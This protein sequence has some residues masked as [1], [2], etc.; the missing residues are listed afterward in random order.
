MIWFNNKNIRNANIIYLIFC[1]IPWLLAIYMAT[2]EMS[3]G[4]GFILFFIYI[5]SLFPGVFF[6][7]PFFSNM[8]GCGYCLFIIIILSQFL[9]IFILNL[10][11]ILLTKILKK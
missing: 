5:F 8:T 4:F 7:Y 3:E 10:I 11:T 6:I 1:I 9:N 2:N